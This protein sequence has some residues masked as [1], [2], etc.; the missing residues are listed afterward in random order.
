[1]NLISAKVYPSFT[2]H[3]FRVIIDLNLIEP[4]LFLIHYSDE[5]IVRKLDRKTRIIIQLFHGHLFK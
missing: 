2:V 4:Y 5:N 1:M 3:S